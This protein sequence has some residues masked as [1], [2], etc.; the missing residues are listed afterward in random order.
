[1]YIREINEFTIIWGKLNMKRK[2]ACVLLG[3]VSLQLLS[4]GQ[5]G[6]NET[7]TEPNYSVMAGLSG[8]VKRDNAFHAVFSSFCDIYLG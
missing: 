6:S 3:A 4:C 7:L 5:H 8:I 1:M 2:I